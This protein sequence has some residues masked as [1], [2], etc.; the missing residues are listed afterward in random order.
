MCFSKASLVC[1]LGR[2]QLKQM[3]LAFISMR[4]PLFT[5]DFTFVLLDNWVCS[6]LYHSSS[7]KSVI[8]DVWIRA[9]CIDHTSANASI[10]ERL[11][12][13]DTRTCWNTRF[14][15]MQSYRTTVLCFYTSSQ[16][17]EIN[18]VTLSLFYMCSMRSCA[19]HCCINYHILV[20]MSELKSL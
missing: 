3:A 10:L 19:A 6:T 4:Y 12:Q 7:H 9:L 1:N 2:K 5:S 13:C 20:R 14:T 17:V 15:S 16:N 18:T 11:D 8:I